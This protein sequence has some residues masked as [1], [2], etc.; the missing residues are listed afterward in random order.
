MTKKFRV[1]LLIS[2]AFFGTLSRADSKEFLER[3]VEKYLKYFN[4]NKLAANEIRRSLC[5]C[6]SRFEEI[7]RLNER[8]KL[9]N[10]KP[11]TNRLILA[12]YSLGFLTMDVYSFDINEMKKEKKFGG[13]VV[14]L[15]FKDENKLLIESEAVRHLLDLL[16]G[17]KSFPVDNVYQHTDSGC[18]YIY[19]YKAGESYSLLLPYNIFQDPGNLKGSAFEPIEEILDD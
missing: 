6:I 2:I 4:V 19:L 16:I 13:R 11:K 1:F 14:S 7:E 10:P 3:D 8:F 15:G 17:E 5:Q 12:N 18:Y 9:F